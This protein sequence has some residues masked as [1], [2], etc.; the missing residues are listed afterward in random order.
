VEL[1]I[2]PPNFGGVRVEENA[3]MMQDDRDVLPAYP[4]ELGSL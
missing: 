2:Y 3:P 4:R 1:G